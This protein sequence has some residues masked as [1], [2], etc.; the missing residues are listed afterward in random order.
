VDKENQREQA[1]NFQL[2][3][4]LH[5]EGVRIKHARKQPHKNGP[6]I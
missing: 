2:A 1:G 5:Y 3:F 4:A 6:V